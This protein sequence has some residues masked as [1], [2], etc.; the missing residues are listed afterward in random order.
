MTKKIITSKTLTN[1][2]TTALDITGRDLILKV[3]IRMVLDQM[4]LIVSSLTRKA[5]TG[6]DLTVMASIDVEE[7]LRDT[8]VPVA[9]GSFTLPYIE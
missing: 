9:V 6:V 4:A 1:K 7:T 8:T 5:M 2:A 3:S